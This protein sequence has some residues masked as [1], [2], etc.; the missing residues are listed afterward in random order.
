MFD[1]HHSVQDRQ[2]WLQTLS[3]NLEKGCFAYDDH[4]PP[5][6]R[7]Q[8]ESHD[9]RF[10]SALCDRLL[11]IGNESDTRLLML[12]V[13]GLA[14][15]LHK[16]T[17]LEDIVIGMPIYK[18]ETGEVEGEFINT[19]VPLRLQ[20]QPDMA[21]R[22]LLYRVKHT[23]D[24]AIAHQN[25]PIRS[26][27]YDLNLPL[28]PGQSPLFDVAILLTNIQAEHYLRPMAANVVFSISRLEGRLEGRVTY[29]A[30][31][32]R[33]CTVE[34]LAAHFVRLLEKLAVQAD[35][36]LSRFEPL[37]EAERTEL[38]VDFNSPGRQPEERGGFRPAA[39]LPRLFAHQVQKTPRQI[40]LIMADNQVTYDAYDKMADRGALALG[41]KGVGQQSITALCMEVSVE[42]AVAIMAVLKSGSAYLPI[43]PESP[44]QRIDYVL[45][46]SGARTVLTAPGDW[47]H[48]SSPTDQPPASR[49]EPY[50][51]LAYVIYTSGSTGRPR[52]VLVEHRSLVNTLVYRQREYG[53][54]PGH[55]ILQLFSYAFD[56]FVTAFF[57]PLIAGARV[58]LLTNRQVRDVD[59]VIGAIVRHRVSHF[60]CVPGLYRV[61]M[62][63]ITPP[64]AASL[65][66]VTLA[67][68][69]VSDRLLEITAKKNPR[70]E[71]VNEYG[72]TEAAVMSSI[73]RNQ[74]RDP[75]I[76]IGHPIWNTGLY[77]TS[78]S[79]QV[80]PVG[81][82]GELNIGGL[83]L[84]R[85]YL[86]NPEL[87]AQKFLYL[88]AKTRQDTRSSPHQPLNPKSQILYRTGD[89]CRWLPEGNLEY[90]GRIDHQVKVRGF[91]IEPAEIEAALLRHA[92]VRSAVVVPRPQNSGLSL[93]AYVVPHDEQAFTV[94][95]LLKMEREGVTA[96]HEWRELPG[97]L[98]LF[99]LNRGETDFMYRENRAELSSLW[100]RGIAVG[101]G[102]VVFDV[103]ANVGL[104]SLL[105]ARQ[106]RCG[107]ATFYLFE[108]IPAICRLLRLNVALHGIRASICQH[109]LGARPGV[110]EFT[111]FPNDSILSGHF[112]GQQQEIDRLRNLVRR[113]HLSRQGREQ[114]DDHLI[115]GL[116]EE[117]LSARPV[118]CPVRTISQVIRENRL[119]RIDLL[120]VDIGKYGPEVLKGV[121]DRD[122][123]RIRQIV[124]E[125]EDIDGTLQWTRQTLARQG[126]E[127]T[128]DRNDDPAAPTLYNIYAVLAGRRKLP[129]EI[130]AVPRRFQSIGGL[131]AEL[132][133]HA[134]DTLPEYMVPSNIILLDELPLTTSGKVDRPAL[135]ETG[136][137]ATDETLEPPRS[138]LEEKVA[139][140]WA[141]VLGIEVERIAAQAS[142]FELGGHSLNATI[143]VARLRQEF[144]VKIPLME[145]FEKPT[146]RA[147]ADR[148]S[149]A[150]A[151]RQPA[152]ESVEQRE[153]YPLS[154]A[155]RRL[156]V[157]WGMEPGNVVYNVP[158]ALAVEGNLDSGRLEEA[159]ARLVRRHESLRTAF[160]VIDGEPVQV[161]HPEVDFKIE[162]A[163][164]GGVGDFT[165]PFDLSRP[166]LMRV[167]LR[168]MGGSRHLLMLDM[169][170]IITDGVSMGILVREFAALYE[171][172]ELPVLK[173]RYRDYARWQ[174]Q[175]MSRQALRRQ[176]AYW[177]GEFQEAV[178]VLPLP[179]D[180]P[181]PEIMNFAGDVVRFQL[182]RQ[183]TAAL[184]EMAREQEATLFM[185][186]LSVFYVLLFRLSGQPDI[187]V[188]IPIAGRRHADFSQ[189]I[190]MFVNTLALRRWVPGEAK[191]G[192]FLQAVREQLLSAYE[193]QDYPFEELV[194]RVEVERNVGHN[195]LFDV[196]FA[197]GNVDIPAVDIP[198][199]NMTPHAPGGRTSRFDLTLIAEEQE[200]LLCTLEFST[201]LFKADTMARWILHLKQVIASVLKEPAG[202]IRRIE[203]LTEGERRQ[204][205]RD[206]N[207][208]AADF[209]KEKTICRLFGE[210]V[211]Q[212]ADHIAVM[213]TGQ[214]HSCLTYRGLDERCR[215]LAGLLRQKGVRPNTLVGILTERSA[216]MMIGIYGIL[217]AG[218]AY[219]PIDPGYPAERVRYML[220]DSGAGI[221]LTDAPDVGAALVPALEL[222][223]MTIPGISAQAN[224][225][226][227]PET[228]PPT[229]LAYVIYTSGSTGNPKGVAIKHLSVVNRL[230]WMQ[231][232]YPLGEDDVLLQKTPV[233]FDVSVWELFWWG[234]QGAA[235]CLLRPGGEKDPEAIIE[236]VARQRVTTLHFVPSMLTIFLDYVEAAARPGQ[237]S[238][239]R[240]VFASGE[241]LT[242][243]QVQKFNRLLQA[244][245]RTRLINLYGP[246]EAT[247]DVSYFNCD[248]GEEESRIP[249]GRPIDN[250]SLY[251]YGEDGQVQP[252][253]VAGELYIAG[254]G[255]APGYL[256]NPDLTADK[257]LPA[258]A[259][260]SSTNHQ[261][262]TPEFIKNSIIPLF[263][264]SIIPGFKR[265]GS[266]LYRTGDQARWRPDGNVEF[267]GRLDHQ[268]KV[269]G[270]R[271]EP[272]EIEARLLDFPAVSAAA[273]VARETEEGDRQLIA[274]VTPHPVRAAAV[275]RLLRLGQQGLTAEKQRCLLPNGLTVFHLNANETD[276]MY[277]EIFSQS[278]YL[279]HGISLNRGACVFDVGA[280]IGL[281]SLFVHQHCQDAHIF[282]FEPM[283]P[284]YELLALNTALY[285]MKSRLFDYGLGAEA[286][287]ADFTYYPHATILSSPYADFRQDKETVRAFIDNRQSTEGGGV[288]LPEQQV[289][290]L[291]QE[292]LSTSR[293]RRPLETLSRVIR[294]N[295]LT[296]IDLLKID[297]EK[298][299]W[300]V[301]QGID[302]GD[303][304]KVR[305]LVMEV[306]DIDGRLSGIEELLRSRGYRLVVE[307]ES[308][309]ENTA[310]YNLYAVSGDLQK[311]ADGADRAQPRWYS[312]ER[313]IDDLK[314]H[315]RQRLPEPMIPAYVVPLERLPLTPNGK[316]DRRALPEPEV[317]RASRFV[318]PRSDTEMAVAA[319]WKQVLG[320]TEVGVHDNFFDVGGNSLKLLEVGL[321]LKK[322]SARDIPVVRMFQHPTV[323]ALA[324]YLDGNPDAAALDVSAAQQGALDEAK[325]RLKK[326]RDRGVES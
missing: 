310:L 273:V 6:D 248:S 202:R 103:G 176:Q 243:K 256:N 188:G 185:V 230:N 105:L 258:P 254:V 156:Y 63:T 15:L 217:Q 67:G 37:G 224:S 210:Q 81:Q 199:L 48:P 23:V 227:Q 255:L 1:Q 238:G 203:M 279:K 239:L 198:D 119:E 316:V 317:N 50:N 301:L 305:Q 95:Q 72:V 49:P 11:W 54:A 260:S 324:G 189:V 99:Y 163:V 110:L 60:I 271:I 102:D 108:P 139:Q 302:D 138:K 303:W 26:L 36:P 157:L 315:L 266:T 8:M 300:Q 289:D 263:Q 162:L 307:R 143:M 78:R 290:E 86:N 155:Q 32:Y 53:L 285:G 115:D 82:P 180:Y 282:A 294:E 123:D 43:D 97:G 69:K 319:A 179:T 152:V 107:Q 39:T 84:A 124:I 47:L 9:F 12:L 136:I 89:L 113:F 232:F 295:R 169:H 77:V 215:G 312:P 70:L 213:G 204:L 79:G 237:L 160:V 91:R 253:G 172:R 197:F 296:A 267:L 229:T 281:F 313:L 314:T 21:F 171:G 250:T 148:I 55:V 106:G 265:S 88:A 311:P 151:D 212:T 46:D 98:P 10:P 304:P 211:E 209:P 170:H 242:V 125:V 320:L 83:G 38:L 195:P 117:Q 128:I 35:V 80:R 326:R 252:V 104:F 251:I 175:E 221:L 64:Q 257:F 61:I 58:V 286:G 96:R 249:I 225:R 187:V 323:A 145:L 200:S 261:S 51:P 76:K 158:V 93:T 41:Q 262:P 56:G 318:A 191:F 284:V 223:I 259:T 278:T 184:Q 153:Y 130:E 19:V 57:T 234:F 27:V 146:I 90:L 52:G 270:F 216:A 218:G 206:F 129:E 118:E 135:P 109:G 325:K 165:R 277:R 120:K 164:T 268:L 18:Q 293:F 247:V 29:N 14:V 190:G 297:V 44:R 59:T 42:M 233:V 16:Y 92:A 144:Q 174:Q 240:Q 85:G 68:D 207:D 112:P 134:R 137:A 73:Y 322:R 168:S 142:F 3:G 299:E 222:D 306:H 283:P 147:L 178:P 116:L 183:T 166:P 235:L 126:Y 75:R 20:V 236:T 208:T 150:A 149:A 245:H 25:Y 269:R 272:A 193:N 241:A 62:E 308:T 45:A 71:V 264:H 298:C 87:T 321:E 30:A 100:E 280:N 287:E 2:Y 101:P 276:F 173:Y 226:L 127:L 34:R 141:D 7:R 5:T 220:A 246:T 161:V 181:R 228:P 177:Q 22:D 66:T 94:R 196:M 28:S 40:A 122:W 121:D 186:L 231:R 167:G 13:S 31:L 154:S 192:E 219:L 291:L 309:L 182:D 274:Y 214:K 17:D 201:S 114:G 244:A 65:E 74:Q 288:L 159:L 194:E 4:R 140:I 205:L 292:R 132:K 275:Q 33:R 111:Y 24:E 131:L 133:R